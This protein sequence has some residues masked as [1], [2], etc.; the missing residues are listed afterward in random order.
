ME[1]NLI[2]R[3]PEK[4]IYGNPVWCHHHGSKMLLVISDEHE[5][6]VHIAGSAAKVIITPVAEA[7][8]RW[9]VVWHIAHGLPFY[10]EVH[11]NTIFTSEELLTA[12]GVRSSVQADHSIWLIERFGGDAAFQGKYIRW[13]DFLNI[14]G[15]GTG[16][17][18]D[19]NVSIHL[20]DKIK[21]AIRGLIGY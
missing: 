18:G 16:H 9:R 12:F 1:E 8:D 19:P 14:P 11:G 10:G 13:K 17:D 7:D 21:N 3:E 2:L 20:D 5:R 6:E 15:P 4:G